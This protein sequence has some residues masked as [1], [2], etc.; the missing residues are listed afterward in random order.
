V[1]NKT[2][3]KHREDIREKVCASAIKIYKISLGVFI[4]G[5]VLSGLT[6]FPLLH[7]LNALSKLL[8][9]NDI[10]EYK[11]YE[12]LKHWIAYINYGL[13]ETYSKYP[14]VGY[15]T[16]W[17]GFAHLIIALFFVKPYLEPKGNLWVLKCGLIACLLV[18]PTALIAGEIRNIPLYWRLIDCSFGLLGAI[19]LLVCL[20]KAR[21]AGI[22]Q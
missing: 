19:P 7:E 14:F 2:N 5:M 6:A 22:E 21:E 17:L 11:Q 16:D 12:G 13:Q 3:R 1:P 15:G 4:T 18:I 8:G 20:K 10:G 9:I